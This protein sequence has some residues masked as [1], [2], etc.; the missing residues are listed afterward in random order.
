M[1]RSRIPKKIQPGRSKSKLNQT[2]P[3]QLRRNISSK[4]ISSGFALPDN[5]FFNFVK[6]FRPKNVF[7]YWFSKKGALMALKLLGLGIIVGFGL[8]YILLAYFDSQANLGSNN[9]SHTGNLMIYDSTGTQLIYSEPPAQSTT[10]LN[11]TSL[12]QSSKYIQDAS[13][14]IEDKNFYHE[15]GVDILAIL[16]S[17]V[18][19]VL[20]LGSSV[21]GASTITEQTVKLDNIRSTNTATIGAKI[22]EFFTAI[23]TNRKYT[24]QAILTHYLN[25]APYGDVNGV[26][27]AAEQYFGINASQLTI[28]ESAL[29]ASIPRDPTYYAPSSANPYFDRTATT[30]RMDYVMQLMYD[31]HYITQ[32]QLTAALKEDPIS[33]ALSQKPIP[34][35]VN[36][37][38][39]FNSAVIKEVNYD[40]TLSPS[41]PRYINPS[42][43][44]YGLKIISTLNVSQQQYVD[45]AFTANTTKKIY[46]PYSGAS[47]NIFTNHLND[48]AFVAENVPTG[49]IT[50]LVGSFNEQNPSDTSNF[51]IVPGS[52]YM[53]NGVEYGVSTRNGQTVQ[54]NS[55]SSLNCATN[56]A[57]VQPGSSF[58]LYDYSALI[59]DTAANNGNGV[60][61]GSVLYDIPGLI[62]CTTLC[63]NPNTPANLGWACGQSSG[64]NCLQDDTGPAEMY[65]PVTLRYALGNSLN[66]P[67]VKAGAIAG[68]NSSGIWKSIQVADQMMGSN[69]V[70]GN[71]KNDYVCIVNNPATGTGEINSQ[72]NY[73]YSAKACSSGEPLI[74]DQ[75]QISLIDH[76]NGYA[77][78]ARLGAEMPYTTILSIIDPSNNKTL[79][80]YT[81]PVATQVVDPQTEYIMM[82]MLSDHNAS[83]MAGLLKDNTGWNI[84]YKSGTQY[85]QYNG[86]V[87]AAS[88]QYAVGMWVGCPDHCAQNP[89]CND[90]TAANPIILP[91]GSTQQMEFMTVPVV[92][93]F[94]LNALKGLPVTNW[95]APKGIQTLPAY[96][97]PKRINSDVPPSN[98]TNYTDIYPSWYKI[99]AAAKSET[100]DSISGN[101]ATSCTPALAKVTVGASY[102]VN[103]FSIDPFYNVS[104]TGKQSTVNLYNSSKTDSI[105][106]CS[107][108]MPAVTLNTVTPD[109]CPNGTCTFSITVQQGTHPLTST[110]HALQ[111]NAQVGGQSIPANCS[112]NP[113]MDPNNSPETATGSCTFSYSTPGTSSL[114][115]QVIDSVLDSATTTSPQNFSV[116]AASIQGSTKTT[117]GTDGSTLTVSWTPN[118]ADK[119]TCTFSPD[120]PPIAYSLSTNPAT[121]SETYPTATKPSSVT[122][123]VTDTSGSQHP[124]TTTVTM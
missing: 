50:A 13:I 88:T 41:N 14:A 53:K 58:K 86:L 6:R 116:T 64:N 103:I 124:Y 20:S 30:A 109:G 94:M 99:P 23:D 24:K 75:A 78:A 56:Q 7:H 48:E 89:S 77:T 43:N 83:F 34:P 117:N 15:N 27:G 112:F 31:Q 119:Y 55:F 68:Q 60:G 37:Y 62:T 76:V 90:G 28:A 26:Q 73:V 101:L 63:S 40:Q 70:N 16:R 106:L 92:K 29:L 54:V 82:N 32:A 102:D 84:A 96:C 122:V 105:H 11:L 36:L 22:A 2:K 42:L 79:F 17:A 49:Q 10:Q 1:N 52:T 38:P 87:M 25:I 95:V 61:A 93:G 97:Q 35:T 21:Y 118:G 74:G 5:F 9:P 120:S 110:Q 104:A 81:K 3:T 98:C 46:Y 18:H 80:K 111:I 4:N 72:G 8:L 45:N 33:L 115:V 121:C 113:T 57:C 100:Y 67:A 51:S 114:S 59:G 65:G 19:D 66:I 107:D 39:N 91:C 85:E 71:E 69:F 108:S 123:T 47:E 12:S 44:I